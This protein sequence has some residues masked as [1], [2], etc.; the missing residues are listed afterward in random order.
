MTRG[1]YLALALTALGLAFAGLVISKHSQARSHSVSV[2]TIPTRQP[3]LPEPA[4]GSAYVRKHHD[5]QVI[6]HR[7]NNVVF[8]N[9]PGPNAH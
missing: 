7:A 2:L 5:S 1:T 4:A 8:T 6:P 9:P 3:S